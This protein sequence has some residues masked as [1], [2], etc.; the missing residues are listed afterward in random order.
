MQLKTCFV[1]IITIQIIHTTVIS[2]P[3]MILLYTHSNA[4]RS[5]GFQRC[6][7]LFRLIKVSFVWCMFNLINVYTFVSKS[8]QFGVKVWRFSL[9]HILLFNT[10]KLVNQQLNLQI[11]YKI[12]T[13]LKL[14]LWK[15][16]RKK[17]LT[18]QM[19]TLIDNWHFWTRAKSNMLGFRESRNF[20][21][22]Y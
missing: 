18:K 14:H 5:S 3:Q 12:S 11:W 1:K 7:I 21:K 10:L 13:K 16:N 6:C 15:K 9:P 17:S 19:M 20:T 8:F 22:Q 4:I 2:K